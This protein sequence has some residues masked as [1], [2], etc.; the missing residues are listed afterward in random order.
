MH[1]CLRRGFFVELYD[2]PSV[3]LFRLPGARLLTMW[4]LSQTSAE[5]VAGP[6]VARV[7]VARPDH[8]VFDLA[9]HGRRCEGARLC[10]VA[11]Q[12]TGE[13][14]SLLE[15]YVRGSDLVATYAPTAKC[16]VRPEIYYRA[17][18]E[19]PGM[20]GGIE[21]I[22]SA[23]TSL[24]G[25]DPALRV[26]ST[27]PLGEVLALRASDRFE[28]LAVA[29]RGL[30]ID[31]APGVFLFRPAGADWSYL[32]MVFPSDFSTA[33]FSIES[34]AAHRLRLANRLFPESL[35]KGVIRRG[36]LRGLFLA[37]S[38]D[39][40]AALTAFRAFAASPPPLTT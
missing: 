21:L 29:P 14:E 39:E 28:S 5:L 2:R 36:R 32:E 27:L 12:D 15:A 40:A 11:P 19:A 16:Q 7:D 3:R 37:R 24:L 17:L 6:L 25:V 38:E 10:C 35:E 4:R 26:E 23:Q 18:S 9:L 33:R 1:L 13:R 8:G 34:E 30:T 31:R 20:F 22:V